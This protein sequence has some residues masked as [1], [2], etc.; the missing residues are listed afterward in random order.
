MCFYRFN[1]QVG[2]S[3][4]SSRFQTTWAPVIRVISVQSHDSH[5]LEQGQLRFTGTSSTVM[6]SINRTAG[7]CVCE[8]DL[9]S[10]CCPRSLFPRALCLFQLKL[11]RW[12]GWERGLGNWTLI[13]RGLWVWRSSCLYLSSSKIHWFRRVIDIFDTDGD[14]E[15]DLQGTSEVI[16]EK[17]LEEWVQ[18]ISSKIKNSQQPPPPSLI[19][20]IKR[21]F[22]MLKWIVLWILLNNKTFQRS[23]FFLS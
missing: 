20:I 18:S 8:F 23:S 2:L 3:P 7:E 22:L 15:V 11:M 6:A 5:G 12:G 9:R 10:T 13:T 21:T 4:W 16:S 17:H 1:L 14:G 19:T